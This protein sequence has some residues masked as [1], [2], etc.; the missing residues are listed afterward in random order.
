[1]AACAALDDDPV[2][3]DSIPVAFLELEGRTL[4]LR[5]GFVWA[6]PPVNPVERQVWIDTGATPYRVYRYLRIDA[7]VAS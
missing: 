5:Q 6:G 7:G 1:M 2:T 4:E 3:G